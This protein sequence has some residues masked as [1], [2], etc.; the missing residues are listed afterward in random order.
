MKFHCSFVAMLLVLS[1]VKAQIS[2]DFNDGDWTNGVNW[3][4]S[5]A[6]W[7]VENGVLRSANATDQ[8]EF[9]MFTNS[10]R[11]Q[12]T[13][14]MLW[15]NLKFN[16]SSANYVDV[17]L[18]ADS[19]PSKA[20]N[21]YYVRIGNTKDEVS[22]YRLLNGTATEIISGADGLLNTSDNTL[23][24]RV[25]CSANY[26]WTL[27]YIAGAAAAYTQAGSIADSAV[28][29]SF[30]TGWRVKQ[31]TTSF[32]KKHY[33]DNY[34][35]GDPILDL[36]PPYI[37]TARF[38]SAQELRIG[39]NEPAQ[40]L[41]VTDTALFSLQ[42]FGKPDAITMAPDGLSAVLHFPGVSGN[43]Q[44]YTLLA[45][46]FRDLAGNPN[47]GQRLDFLGG[48]P[49]L[50]KAGTLLITELMADPDP[51]VANL[52]A[53]EYVELQNI[54]TAY[55]T[56][57]GVRFSDPGTLAVLPDSWLAPGERIILC[58]VSQAVKF[59]SYGRCIGLSPW[60][61]LNNSSDQLY[62]RDAG[63]SW[64]HEVRYDA[65]SYGN[66]TK[67]AGG[68]ALEMIDLQNP[69]D[70]SNWKS[71]S[72]TLGGT[73]GTINS[74]N[75]NKPD[76][77][78]PLIAELYPEDPFLLRIRFS[79]LPDSATIRPGNFLVGS[80]TAL[81]IY[82]GSDRTE[83]KLNFFNPIQKGRMYTLSAGS[84][85]DCVGNM[86]QRRSYP[87]MLPEHQ[88]DTGELLINEVLFDPY[89]GGEDFVELYN[90]SSRCLDLRDLRLANA[91]DNFIANEVLPLSDKG[92]M[93]LP[94]HYVALSAN[95]EFLKTRYPRTAADTG[96][97]RVDALPAY[98]NDAGAVMLFNASGKEL[99]R[100]AYRDDQHFSLI[101]NREGV[102]LERIRKNQPGDLAANWQS[103]AQEAG[104]ATPG[105]P[106]SQEG[107]SFSG[108]EVFQLDRPYFSP[109]MDGLEDMVSLLYNFEGP[110]YALTVKVFDEEGKLIRRLAGNLYA[111]ITGVVKWDG[112]RDDGLRAPAGNYIVLA[113]AFSD[114]G[115]SVSRKIPVALL[116]RY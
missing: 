9:Q 97:Y 4:A 114:R 82:A 59:S 72:N 41:G 95:T 116:L 105:L 75:G 52:P 19:A 54:S 113:E 110:G 29:S 43:V 86:M 91:D 2:E 85:R 12:N 3:A 104:W 76:K 107:Q 56:L 47:T 27:E 11:V 33:F 58:E 73:P 13:Q 87:F 109:D 40:S 45:G 35:C 103:A 98:A 96:L 39:F 64:L 88:P 48:I 78:D 79:E 28:R 42:N 68:W 69:C 55:I 84:V 81:S 20:R 77:T 62:L 112:M 90:S 67:A 115:Q 100:M 60:P 49:A 34:Y 23:R 66:S 70:P 32:H 18:A 36:T 17:F 102:S 16:T 93:F 92:R 38:T 8:A 53:S 94:G 71:C 15:L 44:N 111:G 51:V 101:N 24:L 10:T 26:T 74:V 6:D 46:G 63:N 65:S 31:S 1:P 50:P 21:G 7:A 89:V 83:Y 57:R 25:T 106:N 14:W 22:L 37:S 99:D 80:D 5:S 108:S 61:S 30:F